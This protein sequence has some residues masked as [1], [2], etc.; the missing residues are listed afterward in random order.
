MAFDEQLS[1]ALNDAVAP[2]VAIRRR[3]PRSFRERAYLNAI[4]AV[5]GNRARTL[6]VTR[7]FAARR[8]FERCHSRRF[9]S[10]F[11]TF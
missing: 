1:K 4:V 7:E 8:R 10:A 5:A 3:G 11:E 2:M 9:Q 6:A